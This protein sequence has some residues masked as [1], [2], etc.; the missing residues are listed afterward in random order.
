M[1]IIFNIERLENSPIAVNTIL[2]FNFDQV[3]MIIFEPD[4]EFF[5][6]L[7]DHTF[8]KLLDCYIQRSTKSER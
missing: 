8:E 1:I 5:D 2:R 4:E 3:L 7:R 6:L